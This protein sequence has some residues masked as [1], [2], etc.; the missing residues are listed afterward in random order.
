M[1][2]RVFHWLW[3]RR[4]RRPSRMLLGSD[5]PRGTLPVWRRRPITR[6]EFSSRERWSHALRWVRR[7]IGLVVLLLLAWFIF[8][9]VGALGFFQP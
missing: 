7:G 2:H 6:A 9:S 5:A 1:L 4:L 3:M 8:E